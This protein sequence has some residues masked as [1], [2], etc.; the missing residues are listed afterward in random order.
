[1][2][3]FE[4]ALRTTPRYLNPPGYVTVPEFRKRAQAPD[5]HGSADWDD[6][7]AINRIV[8]GTPEK[9]ADAVGGW[10][11]ESGSTR[12]NLNL[13]IGDMPNWK[14]VKNT[15]LFAEEVIPR[16]RARREAAA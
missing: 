14:V 3:F 9:V 16:L 10:I 5:V 8:A 2:Y 11:E 15:T 7:V 12:L 4:N 1:M 6:L 13:T